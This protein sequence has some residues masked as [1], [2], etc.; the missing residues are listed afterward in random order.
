[1]KLTKAVLKRLIKEEIATLKESRDGELKSY[2]GVMSDE[3]P[4]MGTD[5]KEEMS[6]QQRI[7]EII[8]SI[9]LVE[10]YI[11]KAVDEFTHGFNEGGPV[12]NALRHA[13]EELEA[14]KGQ[15]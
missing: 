7:E 11:R 15:I 10:E 1:M 8:D 5:A 6:N 12:Y 3:V 4:S 14:L 9:E 2:R 13:K